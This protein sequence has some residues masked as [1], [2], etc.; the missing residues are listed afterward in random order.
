MKTSTKWILRSLVVFAILFAGFYGYYLW[1]LTLIGTAYKAKVLCSSVFISNRDPM[2]IL[3][4][5]LLVDDLSILKH[6]DTS[7]DYES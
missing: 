3:T 5:D 2:S 4:N 7:I 1:Q 6:F